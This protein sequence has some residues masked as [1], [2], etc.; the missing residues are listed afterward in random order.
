MQPAMQRDRLPGD[1]KTGE[2]PEQLRGVIVY[3]GNR[4]L[5]VMFIQTEKL[6]GKVSYGQA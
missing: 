1:E 6:E 2:Y 4:Y 3:M 5:V